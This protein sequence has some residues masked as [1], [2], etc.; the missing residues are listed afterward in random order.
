M[1]KYEM[2]AKDIVKNVGGKEN[3]ISLVHCVTRL[4]FNLKDESKA[5]DNVIKSMDGVVTLRK[6]AGQ[7]QVVIGNHV[8]EVFADVCVVAGIQANSNTQ[9]VEKKKLSIGGTILDYISAIMNPTI[10]LMCACGILK[11]LLSLAVFINPE[12]EMAGLYLLLYAASDGMLYF[13]PIFLG[14]NAASKFG[15]SPFL[16]A[17]IGAAL[18]YPSIQGV[19]MNVLGLNISGISYSSTVI[20]I[21]LIIMLA[22]PLE[23]LFKKIIPDVVKTFVVPMLVLA[24]CV[25][26]G[27]CLIGPVANALSDGLGSGISG[28]YGFSPILCG[29]VAAAFWQV[30]VVFG[31]HA[32]LIIIVMVDLM[33]NGANAIYPVFGLPSFAQTAVVFAIWLK[34]KNIKLKNV[35]F[36]A[37]ISGIFG[38]TEPAIY[39]VTLPRIKYFVISCIAAAIGGAYAGL[40]KVTAFSVGGMGIFGIPS[41]MKAGEGAGN[42]I[43]YLLAIAISMAVAFIITFFIYKDEGADVVTAGVEPGIAPPAQKKNGKKSLSIGSP[44]TGKI[45]PLSEVEDGAFSEGILGDGIAVDP[46]VGKILAPADGILST[47]FPTCHALG[48][49]TEDGVELLI[50]IGTDT[51]QLEGKHFFAKVSQGDQ[52]KK[53]QE[54]VE[55]DIPAI[56]AAGYS[57]VTP[58]IVTNTDAYADVIGTDK[59]EVIF[60]DTII[61]IIK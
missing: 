41:M 43:N 44:I 56:K 45:L 38:V 25:P 18:V 39:G 33:T 59:T 17:G 4:R 55:F 7:Y 42:V 10:G 37:W 23:K 32:G 5:N 40:T 36:P 58:V 31:V 61:D 3:I 15:M 20:P 47:L 2:L 50:H 22:A 49:K 30:L 19:E 28:I 13:F 52:I 29:I 27:Y 8:P 9:P 11:G 12:V 16:G 46:K 51:I 53:G 57:V 48:I 21:I 54:L 6:S 24:I 35:A 26:I 60:G 34:T 14:Y 1:G